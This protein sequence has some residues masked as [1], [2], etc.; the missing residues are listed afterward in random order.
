MKSSQSGC[1]SFCFRPGSAGL[2]PADFRP[3][4]L[5]IRPRVETFCAGFYLTVSF[6]L[7][8]ALRSQLTPKR[9]NYQGAPLM[10]DPALDERASFFSLKQRARALL[11]GAAW[12]WCGVCS[13]AQAQ[14]RFDVLNT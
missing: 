13:T 4:L 2:W 14:Y 8:A 7:L 12:L 11:I 5:L 6:L 3:T 9:F 10:P 1:S